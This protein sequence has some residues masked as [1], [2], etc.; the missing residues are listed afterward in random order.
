M[1]LSTNAK[2]SKMVAEPADLTKTADPPRCQVTNRVA[3]PEAS[4]AP[5]KSSASPSPRAC[6]KMG[7]PQLALYKPTG[8]S[9]GP[10]V[11]GGMGVIRGAIAVAP[12]SGGEKADSQRPE[13]G[14]WLRGNGS[15]P[16]LVEWFEDKETGH[17]Q[18]PRVRPA[19]EGHLPRGR[20]RRWS[21]GSWTDSPAANETAW[22]CWPTGAS[23]VGVGWRRDLVD[24]DLSGA[25]GR[26]VASVLFG[27]A[28]NRST[29]AS[30]KRRGSW[31]RR[32]GASLR[33]TAWH[34]QGRPSL[35]PRNSEAVASPS[36]R[37]PRRWG[38]AGVRPCGSWPR[39]RKIEYI[40]Q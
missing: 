39:N 1:G 36:R 37:S 28:E 10:S 12:P 38:S 35:E 13:I 2:P 30:G 22:V 3:I 21:S 40:F 4:A 8:R 29:D 7:I 32:S 20:S 19:A 16:S 26:M 9:P 6:D 15:D 17:T 34:D 5:W 18:T 14:R 25:V 11:M 33:P 27:L 24:I 23:A 31:W